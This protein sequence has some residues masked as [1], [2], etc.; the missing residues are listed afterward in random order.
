MQ[1]HWHEGLFLL[2]HHFQRF[3]RMALENVRNDRKLGWAYPYGVVDAHLSSDDLENMQVKF[4][5]LHA[6]M[7]SG[8]VIDFPGG[9]DL[10]VIN[11][12]DAFQKS[13][14]VTVYLAAPLWS[15]KL[16]NCHCGRCIGGPTG[17]TCHVLRG[18]FAV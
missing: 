13:G 6:V 16:S 11:F 2:P 10:P 1:I 12:K 17:N 15:E 18:N 14:S 4:D 8:L 9:A 5:R 7:P 3:Q